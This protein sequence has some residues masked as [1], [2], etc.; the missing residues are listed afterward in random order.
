[1]RRMSIYRLLCLLLLPL[2]AGCAMG[3]RQLPKEPVL[4]YSPVTHDVRY[5][6]H[7]VLP[8]DAEE[9]ALQAF[10][11]KNGSNPGGNI[12]LLSATP[13]VHTNQERIS[14]IKQLMQEWGYNMPVIIAQDPNVPSDTIRVSSSRVEATAP[15]CP[16]WSYGYMANYRNSHMSNHGCATATNLVRMVEDPNDLVAGTGD[17]NADAERSSGIIDTYREPPA[18]PPTTGSQPLMSGGGS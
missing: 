12:A 18:P 11:A 6:K 17:S 3:E 16:D 15:D 2:M 10:L 14:D 8:S 7:M 1:M 4:T 13:A 9:D 5:P